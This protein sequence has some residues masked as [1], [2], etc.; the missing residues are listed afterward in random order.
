MVSCKWSLQL[1]NK[2][3]KLVAK[4]FFFMMDVGLFLDV[5]DL[6]FATLVDLTEVGGTN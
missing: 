3:A 5:H 2:V 6:F 1:K 4:Y